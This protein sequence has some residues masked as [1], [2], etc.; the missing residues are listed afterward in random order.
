MILAEEKVL[1]CLNLLV[2]GSS[3]RSTERIT[4][5][6]RDTIISLLKIVGEKCLA[7]QESLVRNVKV[8]DVQ[9]D[10]IW[11]YVGMKQ[12]TANQNG[13]GDDEKIGNA[14]TFTA[15]ESTSKLIVAWHLGRRTEADTLIS[16]INSITRLTVQQ[17]AFR[18]PQTHFAVMT[19][20]L[21]KF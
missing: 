5:V 8:K 6:H 10:E 9:A 16:W 2:E 1:L 21:M 12:K 15:I 4:G 17:N 3:I 14:Y 18:C 19:I 20:R 13:L 11:A 7:I